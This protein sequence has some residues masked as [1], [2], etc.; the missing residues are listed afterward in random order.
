MT[1]ML[2]TGAT[3]FLGKAI[4][5]ALDAMYDITTCGRSADNDIVVDLARTVPSLPRRYDIVLHAAAKAH[6]LPRTEAEVREYFDMNVEGTRRLCSALE[7]IGTP[8]ALVFISTVAVYGCQ[9][10]TMIAEDTSLRGTTPYAQSKIQAE[11]V[12]TEWCAAHGCTLTILRPSLI[13]G[14][15]APA[16]LGA[17][18]NGI[19]HG[20]YA[21]VAGGKAAKSMVM[22]HDIA[23]ALP[24]VIDRGGTYNVCDDR[25][26]TFGE[27]SQ[28]MAQQLHRP[29]PLN[30]PYPMAR[31]MATLGD[32]LGPRAPINTARLTK[33]ISP[34]TFSNARLRSLGWTP[35]P[36]LTHYHV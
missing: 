15:N 16:N 4:K 23:R 30:I 12:L 2:M 18:V 33:I 29:K 36:V 11:Q 25:D 13:A 17:M 32:L 5:P 31:L 14:H 6:T 7:R 19:R 1:T 28:L 9:S 8:R 34:L 26:I 22:A 27:L 10:G 20:L 3:G 24:F 35:T 21:N